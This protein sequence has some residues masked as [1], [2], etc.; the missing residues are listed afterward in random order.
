MDALAV[1][2]GL[3]RILLGPTLYTM[4]IVLS[5]LS[6][7]ISLAIYVIVPMIYIFPGR[8][9]RHRRPPQAS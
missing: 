4:S 1:R 2:S 9:D 3:R 5:F 7:W 6:V 8:I